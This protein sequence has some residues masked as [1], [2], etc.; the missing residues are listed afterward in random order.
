MHA[1]QARQQQPPQRRPDPW[2]LPAPRTSR[3]QFIKELTAKGKHH[4]DKADQYCELFVLE[5]RHLKAAQAE[6][7]VSQKRVLFH[8]KSRKSYIDL[9][10]Y[11]YQAA[12]RF[13]DQAKHSSGS[14]RCFRMLGRLF[15]TTGKL[16]Q[17]Q[18][19]FDYAK[20]SLEERRGHD[21]ALIQQLESGQIPKSMQV[22]KH[23]KQITQ[24]SRAYTAGISIISV[25]ACCV[26]KVVFRRQ[27]N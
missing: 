19:F 23:C 17:A 26:Y 8:K 11:N 13:F 16:H 1:A 10:I 14:Q 2:Q 12:I 24:M 15:K 5:H 20:L 25:N 3:A 27:Q 22:H 21:A 7:P 6:V 9:T 4:V 18:T